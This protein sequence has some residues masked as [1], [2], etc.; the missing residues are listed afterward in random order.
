MLFPSLFKSCTRFSIFKDSSR[1]FLSL[2]FK[3]GSSSM[4]LWCAGT[5]GGNATRPFWIRYQGHDHHVFNLGILTSDT[6]E[7]VCEHKCEGCSHLARFRRLPR[8]CNAPTLYCQEPPLGSLSWASW[9]RSFLERSSWLRWQ[10]CPAAYC[11]W[12]KNSICRVALDSRDS[13]KKQLLDALDKGVKAIHLQHHH[14]GKLI[15]NICCARCMT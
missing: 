14:N 10:C 15:L 7:S 4:Q 3:G 5:K 11:G 1:V 8:A 2:I 9:K 13:T 6:G 12:Y